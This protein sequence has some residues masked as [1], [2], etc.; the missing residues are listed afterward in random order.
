MA[1]PNKATKKTYSKEKSRGWSM[2]DWLFILAPTIFLV[3]VFLTVADPIKTMMPTWIMIGSYI[4]LGLALLGVMGYMFQIK[5]PGWLA[6]N[7][8]TSLHQLEPSA[9]VPIIGEKGKPDEFEIY[10]KGGIRAF[11]VYFVGGG[12][13]GIGIVPKDGKVVLGGGVSVYNLGVTFKY[14]QLTEEFK[15][16]LLD[17][18]SFHIG[19]PIKFYILPPNL[20][21]YI[22]HIFSS[23]FA[24]RQIQSLLTALKM[25][26]AHVTQLK[27]Q[28]FGE[29]AFRDINI[30]KASKGYSYHPMSQEER[31]RQPQYDDR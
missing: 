5:S 4:G 29:R 6:G 14:E 2:S 17:L 9:T 20:M 10:E 30:G 19:D 16:A 24:K 27:N 15:E 23:D 12:R 28:T 25:S 18:D 22:I 3:M 1:N 8:H 31:E 7:E 13:K 21:R 26:N 11:G